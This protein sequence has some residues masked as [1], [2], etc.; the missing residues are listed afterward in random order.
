MSVEGTPHAIEGLK[1]RGTVNSHES[2]IRF[3]NAFAMPSTECI[4]VGGNRDHV[5]Y[6]ANGRTCAGMLRGFALVTQQGCPAEMLG[7]EDSDI[8]RR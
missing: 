5:V 7:F 3:A 1:N 8:A 2:V 4:F 6:R